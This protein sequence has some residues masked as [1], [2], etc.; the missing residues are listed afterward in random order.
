[1]SHAGPGQ[2]LAV[3]LE[4]RG[5]EPGRVG[6]K[7]AWTDRLIAA[8][9]R[10]PPTA[11]LTTAAYEAVMADHSLRTLVEQ[12][13]A[14]PQPPPAE[15]DDLRRTLDEAFLEV[16]LPGAVTEALDAVDTWVRAPGSRLAARSSATVEDMHGTSF[17][18]QYRSILDIEDRSGL[19]RG[20][21]LVW[22]SLWY[23]APHAYRRYHGVDEQGIAMAVVVMQQIDALHA[24]VAFTVDPGGRPDLV[25]VETV[26]GSGEQLV[27]GRVTPEVDRVE[28]GQ[29]GHASG[30]AQAVAALSVDAEDRLEA[31]P[32]DLEWAEDE[33]G[34][35]LLQARPITGGSQPAEG[36]GFDTAPEG[37][38]RWTTT[39]IVEMVPGVLPPLRH[40]VCHVALEESVRRFEDRLGNLPS[41]AYG[42]P[43]FG[44]IRGRVVLDRDL[45]DLM[46]TGT[47]PR[48]RW[49][50]LRRALRSIRERRRGLWEA[51]TCTVA[52]WEAWRRMP[53]PSRI[54]DRELMALRRRLIDL[55]GRAMAAEVSVASAAVASEARLESQLSH[56]LDPQEAQSWALRVT[57]RPGTVAGWPT[58]ELETVLGSA[59]VDALQVLAT[60]GDLGQAETAAVR[61]PEAVALMDQVLALVS[62]I[63][64]SSV[65]AGPT[66]Q[67]DPTRWWPLVRQAAD[68]A[69]DAKQSVADPD[70]DPGPQV[71]PLDELLDGLAANPDWVQARIR[72]LQVVDLRRLLIRHQAEDAAD[73]LERR[74]RTKAA[75]LTIGGLI[76]RV[77]LELGDRLVGKGVL[78]EADDVELLAE[79]ELTSLVIGTETAGPSRAELSRRRRWLADCEAAGPLPEDFQGT[80]TAEPPKVPSGDT[81]R[82]WG[83]SPG[84]ARG[85]VCVVRT[86]SSD[87]LRRGDVLVTTST[88]ASW[89]PLL[90]TAGAL[91]VEEGGPLSHAAILARELGI[92]AVV[93]LPGVVERLSDGPDEVTVDGNT[94]VVELGPT[95]DAEPCDGGRSR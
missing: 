60:A 6:G 9:L 41:E 93:N 86:P 66:W 2:D 95:E 70:E 48:T 89:T 63:G 24:G 73:L 5:L 57:S 33:T 12:I 52:A 72:T 19:E 46:S 27:S 13:A 16:R 79:P 18:G 7:G 8:G 62:R 94:G 83:A 15:H 38:R 88:D 55:A 59:P 44:R 25:R 42:R 4:G 76:R 14:S 64:S 40:A 50:S 68:D 49:S 31:G 1:M 67:E 92:P 90:M 21:R 32:L 45:M 23:P 56:H 82:G 91:V 29:L 26:V 61:V 22:A 34:L 36:D 47:A 77:H 85:R 10:V 84:R 20:V 65:L 43:L 69:L 39:G 53:D 35:W 78:D 3:V 37:D 81:L 51:G 75:V 74:E 11:I 87:E 54:D 28:R 80:P 71:S 17:A 30:L 58:R